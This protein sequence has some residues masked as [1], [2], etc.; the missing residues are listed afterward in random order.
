M[1]QTPSDP[2]P[3]QPPTP[4]PPAPSR[5]GDEDHRSEL[6]AIRAQADALKTQN[7][8]LK[9][10]VDELKSLANT[11]EP[12]PARSL[13]HLHLLQIQPVRDLLVILLLVGV[14]YL[15]YVLRPLTIPLLL[16]LALAYLFEPI[17]RRMTAS[18]RIRRPV[19]AI[20]IIFTMVLVVLLPVGFGVAYGT[21]QGVHA[22][23][24]MSVN[25]AAFRASMDNPE[26]QE[27]EARVRDQGWLWKTALE[28]VREAQ[29]EAATV[30]DAPEREGEGERREENGD[31]GAARAPPESTDQRS[32]GEILLSSLTQQQPVQQETPAPQ[33]QPD[34]RA[35]APE[36]QVGEPV[37]QVDDAP[38][39]VQIVEWLDEWVQQSA[40]SIGAAFGRRAVG[41]GMDVLRIVWH[42]ISRSAYLAF[43]TFLVLFFFFFFCVSYQRVLNSLADL[44]PKWKRARTIEMIRKMDAVVSG[45]VRGRLI[46]MCIQTVMFIIGYWLVGVPAP[47]LVGLIIGLLAIVPYLS[48]VGIPLTILLMWLQPV[49]GLQ[50]E[51]MYAWWWVLFAPT[52]VYFIVQ[53]SDDY[54]WTPT[55]QGK[56]TDMDIPSILFA[57]LAGGILAGFYGV[58]L[59]IPVAACIKVLLKEAFWPRFKAW[60][61]GR[62]KDFLPISRYDPT[63]TD[64]AGR[65]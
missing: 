29:K 42:V 1:S 20:S 51:F 9:A 28:F 40:A 25:L 19:A 3:S 6:E 59:A 61:E 8:A 38:L 11:G 50:F 18:G 44:I 21:A 23:R 22:G 62:V 30:P 43:A 41:T 36:R 65:R 48:L 12:E 39:S 56:A 31:N 5:P 54:I 32:P 55:I 7:L 4:P 45:F 17:V 63:T 37:V 35:A 16:A 60:S 57:V 34:A 10:Q 53:L 26:D 24:Q 27:L 47:L 14:V 15:G 49:P 64:E 33:Q 58:L 52:V 13:Q 2:P 46:I